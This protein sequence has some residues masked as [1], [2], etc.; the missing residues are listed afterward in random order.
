MNKYR[1]WVKTFPAKHWA[2]YDLSACR[3]GW[4]SAIDEIIKLIEQRKKEVGGAI[5]PDITIKQILEYKDK[6]NDE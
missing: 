1:Q 6:S 4:D 2:K 5:D 3:L